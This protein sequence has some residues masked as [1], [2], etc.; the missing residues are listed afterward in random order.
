[1]SMTG[2]GAGRLQW[3]ADVLSG[4]PC[5]QGAH[6]EYC[7]LSDICLLHLL[8]LMATLSDYIYYET[9]TDENEEDNPYNLEHKTDW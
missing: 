2:T 3:A 4:G 6:S 8:V 9:H 7:E 1:M 5:A